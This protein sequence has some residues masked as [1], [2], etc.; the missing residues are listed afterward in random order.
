MVLLEPIYIKMIKS[1]MNKTFKLFQPIN[2]D[3]TSAEHLAEVITFLRETKQPILS[4]ADDAGSGKTWRLMKAFEDMKTETC[5][6]APTNKLCIKFKKSGYHTKTLFSFLGKDTRGL[7]RKNG[8]KKLLELQ[9]FYKQIKVVCIDEC[10]S[11]R[12]VDIQQIMYLYKQNPHW[13]L[14][15]SGDSAQLPPIDP[16]LNE[17]EINHEVEF[18]EKNFMKLCPYKIHYTLIQRFKKND[19]T[20]DYEAIDKFQL[21]K[22]EIRDETIP[23]TVAR[24][25]HIV[26]HFPEVQFNE[27][28]TKRNICMLNETARK[29]NSFLVNL[30]NGTKGFK[31]GDT[32][33]CKIAFQKDD[34]KFFKNNEFSIK[35]ISDNEYEVY[36]ELE[37]KLLKITKD[38]FTSNFLYAGGITNHSLQGSTYEAKEGKVTVLDLGVVSRYNQPVVSR[39]WLYVCLSRCEKPFEDLQVCFNSH[40]FEVKNLEWKIRSHIKTDIEKGIE[41]DKKK[42]LD[43]K[44]FHKIIH[45][46]SYCCAQCHCNLSF[47][48][49]DITDDYKKDTTQYSLN[50]IRNKDKDGNDL[51]LYKNNTNVVCLSCNNGDVF[52][53]RE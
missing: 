17:D 30:E 9:M 40:I 6:V 28:K 15:F 33:V 35:S 51:P 27:I 39:K 32:I 12:L 3:E 2:K 13:K 18:L 20:I 48:Y 52:E 34:Y 47:D 5:F 49:E 53:W 41:L 24:I 11:M 22:K 45:K 50:R 19:G 38:E 25:K 1:V 21:I 14:L 36:E 31:I 42:Y 8:N 26:R 46:Q 4:T 44:E 7:K 29:T 37:E 43:E 10:F 23:W 16:N